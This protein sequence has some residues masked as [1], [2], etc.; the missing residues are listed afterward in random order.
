MDFL[1]FYRK[2]GTVTEEKICGSCAECGDILREGDTAYFLGERL[3]CPSCVRSSLT[4][5]GIYTVIPPEESRGNGKIRA[6]TQE[7]RLYFK[8]SFKEKRRN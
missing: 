4:A 5:V 2:E 7:K 6:G 8:E 3:Y 1:W